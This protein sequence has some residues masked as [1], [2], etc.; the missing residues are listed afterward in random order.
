MQLS[1]GF[2]M[3]FHDDSDGKSWNNSTNNSNLNTKLE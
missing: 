3:I 2:N 1:A